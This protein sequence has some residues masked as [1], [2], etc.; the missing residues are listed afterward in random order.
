MLTPRRRRT[1]TDVGSQRAADD[2]R[3]ERSSSCSAVL[4]CSRCGRRGC[5]SQ[6]QQQLLA[7]AAGCS[8]SKA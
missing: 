3:L 7:A 6:V 8:C 5:Y 2:N 1:R 4:R